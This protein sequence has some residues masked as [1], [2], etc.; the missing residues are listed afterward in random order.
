MEERQQLLDPMFKVQEGINC[1]QIV[2]K[3]NSGNGR[4]YKCVISSFLGL[5]KSWIVS[6][7]NMIMVMVMTM[8]MSMVFM[9]VLFMLVVMNIY[10][11][12]SGLFSFL[13]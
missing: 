5:F 10:L 3:R 2:E 7:I 11:F 8:I 9:I 1:Q 6:L 4:G 12:L 13:N